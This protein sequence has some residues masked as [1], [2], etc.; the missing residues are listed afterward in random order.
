MNR[1]K[2]Q[3]TAMEKTFANRASEKGL[4]PGRNSEPPQR[5]NSRPHSP[6]EKRAEGLQRRLFKEDTETGNEQ[7]QRRSA[8]LR[9][10]AQVKTARDAASLPF[11]QLH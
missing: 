3:A 8:S 11:R 6:T 9:L 4:T 1:V 5:S 10:E 2:T 7:M